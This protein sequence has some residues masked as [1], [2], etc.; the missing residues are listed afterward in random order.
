M[1]NPYGLYDTAGNVW[2]WCGDRYSSTYYSSSPTSNPT[3][4]AAGQNRV[5]RGGAWGSL[6]PSL[7]SAV[8]IASAAPN[9]SPFVGFRVVAIRP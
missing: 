3:G 9:R 7:R 4:P 5:I 2:E 8:R 1:A 6:P